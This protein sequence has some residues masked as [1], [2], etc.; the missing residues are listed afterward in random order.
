MPLAGSTPLPARVKVVNLG[1]GRAYELNGSLATAHKYD[2]ERDRFAVSLSSGEKIALKASNLELFVAPP[3]APAAGAPPSAQEDGL[4]LLECARYG[5]DDDLQ[6]MLDRGVPADF[7]DDNGSTALHKASANGH[8]GC[9]E[10]L[11]NAGASH[12]ANHSGNLPLH[13]ATQQGHAAVVD[14][15]LRRVA[16]IDVLARNDAGRSVTTE[17]FE[18][19]DPKLVEL[20]LNHTSAKALEPDGGGADGDDAD[21]P[22]SGEVTHEFV[23]ADGVPT[24]SIRELGEIGG[25]D[26]DP[27][28][29]L[30]ATADD[31]KTGLQLWAA[32]LVL[33]RWLVEMRA[34][35]A[36]R[37]VVE[38]GAG[39]GL[40]GVVASVACGAASVVLS[41][42]AAHSM[43]NL[44]HNLSIN[45]LAPPAASAAA[46]DWRDAATWPAAVDVVIGADLVYALSAVPD[47]RRVVGA[48]VG[49]GGCFLYVCPE[50]NRQGEEAFIAGLVEDGFECQASA[51]PP[52]YLA[53]PLAET[54]EEEFG[55]L[56]AELAQRTYTLY[57]FSRPAGGK[58]PPAAK[59]AAPA[60]A[61]AG[62]DAE[63][64]AAVQAAVDAGDPEEVQRLLSG[65]AAGALS[66]SA[67]KK[68]V[69]SAEI[70]KKRKAQGKPAQP[71]AAAA[72]PKAAVAAAAAAAAAAPVAA[73]AAPSSATT[74]NEDQVV[75][76]LLRCVRALGLP[77]IGDDAMRALDARSG[78]IGAAVAP[79]LNALRNRAYTLGFSA[80]EEQSD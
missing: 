57:C 41:D 18:R 6:A 24:I 79:R 17:A 23:F 47:L 72:A 38:L 27:A 69:K 39:C 63:V 10:R 15:L 54:T 13:W 11:L 25:G 50:T 61:A 48:L 51:V 5:E 35:L 65:G 22:L 68:L 2:G 19:N 58:A 70:A 52:A 66:K 55:L 80:A 16:G 67:Q 74:C 28:K 42:L 49:P 43:D 8:V 36:G 1:G 21:A 14:V 71:A 44:R 3:P 9:V 33:S 26:D 32:S 37:T 20:V 12:V 64:P 62:G 40:C 59:G 4:E 78:E 31:D 45:G 30:G 76:E 60:P 53:N 7:T 29:W 46:V 75:G 34:R 73:P 77:E 56:F